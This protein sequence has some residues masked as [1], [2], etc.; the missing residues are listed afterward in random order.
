MGK[1]KER[2]SASYKK[3]KLRLLAQGKQN[4][5]AACLKGKMDFKFISFLS[6]A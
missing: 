5:R 2:L 6:P 1:G 4:L 3:S